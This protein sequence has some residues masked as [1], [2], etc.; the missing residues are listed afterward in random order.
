MSSIRKL[1]AL[2]DRRQQLSD[3]LLQIELEEIKLRRTILEITDAQAALEEQK[4]LAA[5]ADKLVKTSTFREKFCSEYAQRE[6]ASSILESYSEIAFTVIT[7]LNPTWII[8]P[9]TLATVAT[10]GGAVILKKSIDAYC[11]GV[12]SREIALTTSL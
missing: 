8:E 5:Y 3:R 11:A 7:S 6:L 9:I 12:R 10:L 2:R 1:Q 4:L